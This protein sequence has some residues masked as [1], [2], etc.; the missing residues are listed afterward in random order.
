MI[1]L[2]SIV[3]FR[4]EKYRLVSVYQSFL[5]FLLFPIIAECKTFGWMSKT[6]RYRNRLPYSRDEFGIILA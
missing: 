3:F 6:T 4:R 5:A 2:G 1:Y